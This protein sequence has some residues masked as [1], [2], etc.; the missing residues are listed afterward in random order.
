MYFFLLG[1]LGNAKY[2]SKF[3]LA[4]NSGVFLNSWESKILVSCKTTHIFSKGIKDFASNTFPENLIV[5]LRSLRF[6]R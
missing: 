2:P 6:K 1:K 5:S 3:V 4:T